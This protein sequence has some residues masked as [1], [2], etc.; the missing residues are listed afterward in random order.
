[1]TNK[2]E[3]LSYLKDIDSSEPDSIGIEAVEAIKIALDKIE[4]I[5][6]SNSAYNEEK[7]D[8]FVNDIIYKLN[9]DSSEDIEIFEELAETKND[10]YI[11]YMVSPMSHTIK[12]GQVFEGTEKQCINYCNNHD[13]E[14]YDSNEFLWNL[15]IFYKSM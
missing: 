3:I 12:G 8:I 5:D 9:C 4:N 11:V 6:F 14:K 10:I 1:M 2:Q 13:W 15:D 7:A